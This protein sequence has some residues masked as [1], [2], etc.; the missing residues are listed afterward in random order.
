MDTDFSIVSVWVGF[1]EGEEDI[2]TLIKIVAYQR[3]EY[4]NNNYK[5]TDWRNWNHSPDAF[6]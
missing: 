4:N 2:L 6:R 3:Q 5:L 1:D